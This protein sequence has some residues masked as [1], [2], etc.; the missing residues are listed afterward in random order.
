[1]FNPVRRTIVSIQ[2]K[3]YLFPLRPDKFFCLM[4]IDENTVG[5]GSVFAQAFARILMPTR[6]IGELHG[7]VDGYGGVAESHL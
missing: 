1:M 5:N 6:N 3:S 7:I 4:K 2:W